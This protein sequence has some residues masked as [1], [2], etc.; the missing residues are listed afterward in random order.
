MRNLMY[1]KMTTFIITLLL[2]FSLVACNEGV[3]YTVTFDLNGGNGSF[4]EIK[5]K[6]NEMVEEPKTKPTLDNYEFVEWQ[7]NGE[8]FNFSNTK[9]TEDITLVA[10]YQQLNY[11]NP[12]WE[13]ILADP[14]VIEHEG[15]YYAFG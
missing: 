12:V 11:I 5:V 7:L 8:K 13:P 9:I 10:F 1:K 14:S 4:N 15:V 6:E 3:K 2:T